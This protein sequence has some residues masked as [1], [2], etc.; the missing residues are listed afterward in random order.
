MGVVVTST[1]RAPGAE[2]MTEFDPTVPVAEGVTVLEAS[3]GTG[4]T[5]AVSSLVVAEV[6]E[7]RPL[8][9]LLVVTFTRKATG[10]LRERVWQRLTEA[11]AALVPGPDANKDADADPLV[12]HLRRGTED[13]RAARRR[14]LRV[15]LSD[16]DA[17]TIAT[18]HGFCQQV[19]ASLGTAGDAERDVELVEDVRDL[20]DDAVRDLYVRRVLAGGDV[21]FGPTTASAIARAVVDHPDCD[22]ASVDRHDLD[23]QRFARTV[24][25]RIDDQKRKGRLLTYDDLLDRLD[26]SLSEGPRGRIVAERL[27]SRFSMAVVDEFQDTDTIQWRILHRAFGQAPCRLVLVGDPKQAIYAFRGGDVHAYLEA[28]RSADHQCGLSTSWRADRPLLTALDAVFA[29]AQLGD[30]AIR[31]RPV[32]ARPGADVPGIDGPAGGPPLLVKVARNDSGRFE[33]TKKTRVAAKGPVRRFLAE[34]LAAEAVCLLNTGSTIDGRPLGPGDLAVLTRTHYEATVARDALHAVGVPAVVHG[35]GSVW[36]TDAARHW[37]ALLDALEQP[38]RAA[39]VRTVAIGPFVGW[40]AARLATATDADWEDLDALLHDWAATARNH[41]VAGVLRRVEEGTG[42]SARL[43]GTVG[44][45]RLLSDLRHLAELLHARQASH[46]S[47]LPTLSGWIAEQRAAAADPGA[48]S[49]VEVARR[50]LETDAAAVAV[51]TIHSAK[52]LEF[53]VVLLPSLWDARRQ[54]DKDIATFHDTDGNRALSVGGGGDLR[55]WQLDR[56]DDEQ[57]QEELRLLYVALTRARHRVV[58]W[59]ASAS[60]SDRSPLARVLLATDPVTGAVARR[61]DHVP[62]EDEIAV[63]LTSRLLPTVEATGA[64]GERYEP[65]GVDGPPLSVARFDRTF[66]RCWVRTSYSGLTRVAHET[67]PHVEVDLGTGPGGEGTSAAAGDAEREEAAKVDEPRLE[68]G[69]APH[70]E[71]RQDDALPLPL[72]DVPGGARVGTLV[73]EMLEQVDFAAPDL[74]AELTTAAEAAGASRLVDGHEATLVDGVA[75]ALTTPWGAAWDDVRL[76]DLARADRLDELAFDLPLAGGDRPHDRLVTMTAIAEVFAGLPAD[77]PLTDYH[78]RLRDPLLA[79]E[80]RGF[81]SGSIDLVARLGD[82]R[83]RHVVVDYKTNHLVPHGEVGSTA[84]Y[85][86]G[87]LTAAMADAHYPLQAALYAVALH[88]FLRWRLPGYDP[89]RHLGGVAY[90]F[91][92]GMVGPVTPRDDGAP[93]GVFTWQ[94]PASFVTDLSDLL[95]RGAP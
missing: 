67:G 59:W 72:A 64:A 63:E 19:L 93:S 3:A 12:A 95:D 26:A 71:G 8:D 92:R 89:A 90:L 54:D 32:Q 80:V 6:A 87:A 46:P 24:R 27:R 33:L 11:A 22:I 65:P 16:F 14:H 9:E 2:A 94:P 66:D 86:P 73:H 4:K 62:T 58:A 31:H 79:T 45:D 91:L 42:L 29:G 17:A 48:E 10:E 70:E 39:R 36:R 28:T 35:A 37:G 85:R 44:G 55:R 53:P 5:H 25:R 81:L 50:R 83:T 23:R 57:D 68:P 30:E 78:E 69:A 84:H 18:T 43:L 15:A 75:L 13:E 34:D 61:L 56:A 21:P 7:G 88:R 38:A 49:G 1:D 41:T 82:D 47:S 76:C 20:V 52:G 51:H 74:D 40:D 60:D 77:D